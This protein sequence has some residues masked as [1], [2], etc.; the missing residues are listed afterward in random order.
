MTELPCDTDLSPPFVRLKSK[1]TTG[2]GFTV[3]TAVLLVT[4]P[5]TAVILLVRVEFPAFLPVARP[6]ELMVAAEVLEE[7][8]ANKIPVIVAPN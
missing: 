6:V 5:D 3:K 8:H 4:L 2:T 1:G 7:F